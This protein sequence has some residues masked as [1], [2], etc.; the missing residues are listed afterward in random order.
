VEL[1]H[2]GP[3]ELGPHEAALFA[4]FGDVTIVDAFEVRRTHPTRTLGGW[5]LKPFAVVHSGFAEVLLLDA[6]NVPVV[7]P[8]F[9]F[10]CEPYR[11]TGAVFWPDVGRLAAGNEIWEL[12]GVPY[13]S[14]PA[15]ES[16]QLVVDKRR[17]RHALALALH[18][19]MHSDTFYR[20]VH[21]DKDTWHLA[22]RMI[23]QPVA[24]TRYPPR[25]TPSGLAQR[26]FDGELLFQHRTLGKWLLRGENLLH[27]GFELQ[28]ECLA[29]L[30]EL[31]ARWTGRISEPAVPEGPDAGL[32][33]G[34]VA[35]RW[36][37]REYLG[38][39]TRELEL[40]EHGRIGE[41]HNAHELRWEV[42]DSD[43]VFEGTDGVTS[44]LQ[45]DASGLWR[46]RWVREPGFE[47]EL[48]P[49]VDEDP[50]PLGPAVA[51]LFARAGAGELLPARALN[52][53]CALGEAADVSAAVA[54]ERRSWGGDQAM[55]ELLGEL[56]R[57]LGILDPSLRSAGADAGARD[58]DA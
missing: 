18:M 31:G 55:S 26:G 37:R 19:N 48:S 39:E 35:G 28:D 7:D 3:G 2:L 15:W 21:G 25:G 16:A 46:G 14:E 53:L 57:R 44:R 47:V 11:A 38:H 56:E 52:A 8:S 13:R 12:C 42:R 23:D 51:L 29:H 9:L 24:M 36:W 33:A 43:L 22:W 34:L 40:L 10:D 20:H 27:D 41:G 30:R 6:D 5:E 4:E 17:C 54:R 58:D 50:G 1:W 49:V 45:A 32:T